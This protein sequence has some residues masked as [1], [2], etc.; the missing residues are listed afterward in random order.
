ML[1]SNRQYCVEA[2]PIFD[3]GSFQRI[4]EIYSDTKQNINYLDIKLNDQS[5]DHLN[6]IGTNFP[7]MKMAVIVNNQ[8]VGV[9]EY[10]GSGFVSKITLSEKGTSSQIVWIQEE[11]RK[12]V[13]NPNK[14]N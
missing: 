8:L 7:N 5:L 3:S 10:P 2:R 14:D 6:Q 9:I 12:S 4:G 1:N 11:L 13:R